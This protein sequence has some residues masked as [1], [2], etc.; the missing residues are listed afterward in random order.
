MKTNRAITVVA[1]IS[2]FPS[3]EAFAE[4][5]D[6]ETQEQVRGALTLDYDFGSE[7]LLGYETIDFDA[8]T[9]RYFG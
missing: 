6:P 5:T 8:M 3:R 2:K 9:S 4:W 1:A 7:T